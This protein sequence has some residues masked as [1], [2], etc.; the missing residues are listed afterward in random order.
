MDLLTLLRTL[1]GLGIVLGLLATALWLVRR[2]DIKLPGRVAGSSRRRLELVERLPID[3][4]RSVALIRRDGRE[5][6]ILLA[7]EG[8]L[9]VEAS[10][11]RDEVDEAAEQARAIAEEERAAGAQAEAAALRESF[12]TMVERAGEGVRGLRQA[13]HVR[14]HDRED[15]LDA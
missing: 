1:G 15:T 10:I 6:M 3:A 14:R 7:P 11:V 13:V 2:Y 5:H 8:T 12:A 9:V 4:R